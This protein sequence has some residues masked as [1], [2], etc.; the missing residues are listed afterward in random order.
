MFGIT[1]KGKHSYNDYGLTIKSKDINPPP[2]N[3]VKEKVPYMQG[4][5]DFSNLYGDQTYNERTLNYVF[6]LICSS[7][8]ELNTKKIKILDWLLNSFKD[9]LK[10]D[11]IPGFYFFAECE[12]VSF[13]EDGRKAEITVKFVAYP[14]KIS[15]N[16]E[17]NI[18]W[19]D[20]N[21]E[22]DYMQETKF[23]IL[24]SKSIEIYNLGAVK[25][26]PTII[27]SAAMDIIK[28][29][30]T[31]K[32]NQGTT[33]DWRFT[34]DKGKNNLTIKGTGNIEFIFRREVL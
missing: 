10:D 25:A 14:F 17:G 5:Y 22:L 15:S 32:Y 4:A 7:K 2:K 12:D 24:G 1:Y 20:F 16:D 27:C 18:P 21:F 11:T 34:L 33:K 19:D 23:N 3:K 8:L 30:I 26:T 31:Y 28:N 13:K 29:G 9:N 6:N